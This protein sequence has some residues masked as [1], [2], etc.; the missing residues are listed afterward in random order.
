ML[1]APALMALHNVAMFV[2]G[3]TFPSEPFPGSIVAMP[4]SFPFQED[5]AFFIGISRISQEEPISFS[6]AF[7]VALVAFEVPSK[8]PGGPSREPSPHAL[9]LAVQE[10]DLLCCFCIG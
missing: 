7:P 1:R 10:I 2:F 8:R 6:T 9:V 3:V 5:Q 4:F